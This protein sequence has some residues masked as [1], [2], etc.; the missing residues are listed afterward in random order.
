M[1]YSPLTTRTAPTTKYGSRNGKQIKRIVYHHTGGGT[2]EG[3]IDYLAYNSARAS[4]TYLITT[5]AQLVGMVPEEFRPWTTGVAAID[6]EAVTV[7]VV[8]TTHAPD[9]KVSDAQLNM[10]A[11]LTDDVARRYGWPAINRQNVTGHRE[12]RATLCPGPYIWARMDAIVA[13]ANRIHNSEPSVKPPVSKPTAPPGSPLL[14]LTTPMMRNRNVSAL[15][16]CINYVVRSNRLVVD[17]A[18]GRNTRNEVIN[19]QA[20]AGLVPDG[21]YGPLTAAKLRSFIALR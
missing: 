21:V 19:L 2:D 3:N 6:E 9:W 1:T 17:G 20:F 14:R 18:Y 4:S 15:Q 10:L 8:N 16:T 12:H 7:E 11:R 13:D 5:D